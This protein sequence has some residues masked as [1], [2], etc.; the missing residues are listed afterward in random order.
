MENELKNFDPVF[1]KRFNE[2]IKEIKQYYNELYGN[3]DDFS[4]HFNDLIKTIFQGYA[5]RGS[6]L[7]QVDVDREKYP[8]WFLSEK[9]MGMMLYVDLFT[10]NLKELKNRNEYFLD[11]GVDTL[12]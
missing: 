5:T 8:D 9:M 11:L 3:I 4:D 10:G 1:Q 7:I 12:L 2:N 6:E